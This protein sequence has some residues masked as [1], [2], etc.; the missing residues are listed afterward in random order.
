MDEELVLRA[1][2]N[3]EL[4]R[5][6]K[7]LNEKKRMEQ[8]AAFR[9]TKEAKERLLQFK[10]RRMAEKVLAFNAEAEDKLA[11]GEK[12]SQALKQWF[13][14]ARAG[15]GKDGTGL[16]CSLKGVAL[17]EKVASLRGKALTVPLGE[18]PDG[19]AAWLA[20]QDK[21]VRR[22]RTSRWT[23]RCR[24]LCPRSMRCQRPTT[25]SRRRR[26]CCRWQARSSRSP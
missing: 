11:A 4:D 7:L 2:W 10:K 26:R 23:S 15:S 8:E 3:A 14:R 19:Y 20:Q 17:D 5:T 9:A 21:T 1:R 16:L 22:R 13:V 24:R 18:E 6:K 25:T 12:I